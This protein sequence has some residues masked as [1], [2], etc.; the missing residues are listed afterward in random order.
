MPGFGTK[1]LFSVRFAW[2]E[3]FCCGGCG[4]RHWGYTGFMDFDAWLSTDCARCDGERRVREFA[5]SGNWVDG[6]S[7]RMILCSLCGS[8]R[9]PRA[10]WHGNDCSGMPAVWEGLD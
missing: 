10:A 6:L 9:C 3:I 5:V 7:M 1:V 4:G 8:K 2:S